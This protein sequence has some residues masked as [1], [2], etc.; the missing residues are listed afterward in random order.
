M[1]KQDHNFAFEMKENR[2]L[3]LAGMSCERLAAAADVLGSRESHE[4]LLRW[5]LAG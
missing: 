4:C 2:M 5:D 1:Q 3:L